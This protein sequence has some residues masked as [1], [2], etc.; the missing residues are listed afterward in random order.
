MHPPHGAGQKA[1]CAP[2]A[3]WSLFQVAH[4]RGHGEHGFYIKQDHPWMS[5]GQFPAPPALSFKACCPQRQ[6][7]V[8]PEAPKILT[9]KAKNQTC[10]TAQYHGRC[11]ASS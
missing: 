2:V 5:N 6:S 7:L 9:K 8:M 4:V 1:F 11:G 3:K 10:G